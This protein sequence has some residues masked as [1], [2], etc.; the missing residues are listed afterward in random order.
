MR[1]GP[2]C[3]HKPSLKL[4]LAC[5]FTFVITLYI[6][7][8]GCEVPSRIPTTKLEEIR[9]LPQTV[10]DCPKI[11]VKTSS[12]EDE[13]SVKT[14]LDKPADQNV[15]S[16]DE[17]VDVV[18]NGEKKLEGRLIGSEAFV[19]FSFVKEYF[20]IYGELQKVDG[21]T[22]LDWRHSYSDIHAAKTGTVYET[23]HPF[24]WF[25]TYHVEGRTRVKCISGIEEVPVSSQWNAKGHFYPIQIAQYGL[26]HY[27]ML[28]IEGDS[29]G[30]EKIFEDAET[31]SDVNWNWVAPKSAQIANV[32]DKER[33]S[34][35]FQFSTTGK[36][37]FCSLLAFLSVFGCRSILFEL[38]I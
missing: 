13:Q 17:R 19:P 22:V 37:L 6:F 29:E 7:W 12:E 34:R 23:K 11:I 31:V 2:F 38:T 10:A 28:K 21:R 3:L 16:N 5:S 32:F 25:E 35:V 27:N 30:K 18:V 8:N 1:L 26:S 14:E 4:F 20:E 24:L 15:C 33:N 9:G 36:L